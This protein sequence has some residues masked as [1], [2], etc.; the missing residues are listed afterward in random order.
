VKRFRF[1]SAVF[2]LLYI[3]DSHTVGTFG[4]E[5]DRLLRTAEAPAEVATYGSCGSSPEWWVSG[6]PTNC[7]YF[8]HVE[9]AQ[10]KHIAGALT[11]ILDDL[12]ARLK[13]SL[14]IVELGAN[15][16]GSPRET[17]RADASATM[18]A[19]ADAGSRCIWIGPP[20]GRVFDPAKFDEMYSALADAAAQTGCTLIDS[21]PWLEYP[22]TGGDGIHYDSLGATGV[23]MAKDWA[24]KVFSAISGLL[25]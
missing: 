23:A 3:G 9:S 8:E 17:I 10:P 24:A 5:L 14:T 21:R 1:Q 7:G 25:P 16:V 2:I 4:Q 19:I 20:K 18:K 12:L 13:P 6:H 15:E 22:A 11:P